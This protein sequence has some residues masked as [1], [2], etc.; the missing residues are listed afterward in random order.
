MKNIIT[1]LAISAFTISGNQIFA[2]QQKTVTQTQ[3]EQH[4][5]IKQGVRNGE[6]TKVEAQRLRAEQRRIKAEKQMAKADGKMTKQERRRL[7]MEQRK[8]SQHIHQEKHD[9]EHK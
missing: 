2:Q 5:R 9:L 3:V 8:A 1:I 6:L 4:K 7:K